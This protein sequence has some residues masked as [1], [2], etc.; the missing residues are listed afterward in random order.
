MR[1]SSCLWD[2][3]L[4]VRRTIQHTERKILICAENLQ[5]YQKEETAYKMKYCVQACMHTYLYINI[6]MYVHTY[7]CMSTFEHC[8]VGQTG[9]NKK[10]I[11][12]ITNGKQNLENF[13]FSTR[14]QAS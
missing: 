11:E 12:M 10:M 14:K 1:C 3:L 5:E 7:I 13:Q 9:M 8:G 6:C 2:S 4:G